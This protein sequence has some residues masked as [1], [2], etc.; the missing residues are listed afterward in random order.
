MLYIQ[1][2]CPWVYIVVSRKDNSNMITTILL[3]KKQV[4]LQVILR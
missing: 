3:A 2:T 4:T 1:V